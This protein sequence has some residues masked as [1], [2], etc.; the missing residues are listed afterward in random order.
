M[1]RNPFRRRLAAPDPEAFLAELARAHPGRDY[2]KADRY[3]DFRGLFLGDERGRRVLYEILSWSGMYRPSVR[4]G[5]FDTTEMV[6]HEGERNI[7]LQLMYA[8]NAEPSARPTTT[9]ELK[10][11]PSR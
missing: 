1:I 7:A 8:M 11:A 10:N 3:A 4:T 2:S 5:K 6:F 9:K